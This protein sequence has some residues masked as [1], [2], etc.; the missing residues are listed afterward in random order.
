MILGLNLGS[1][2]TEVGLLTKTGEILKHKLG[3]DEELLQ[4]TVSEQAG[5]RTEIV[6]QWIDAQGADIKQLSAIACRGGRLKPIPSGVYRVN[7][8]LMV[9][10]ASTVHGDH[11]SRLSVIIGEKIAKVAACPLFVVDPISVDELADVARISGLNGVE[12]RSLG[13]MLNCKY[14]ARHLSASLGKPYEELTLIVAHL[15]GGA[16]VSLHQNG[17]LTDLINDFE[18]AF[19]PERMGGMATTTMTALCRDVDAVQLSRFIEGEGGFYSYL[20]TKNLDEVNKMAEAGNA[21]AKLLKD[22]YLYQQ[23]KSIGALIAAAGGTIDALAITGGIAHQA[24]VINELRAVFSRCCPIEVYPG[25]FE[26]EALLEGAQKAVTGLVP[27]LVYPDGV[28]ENVW[29]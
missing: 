15:G 9:D 5:P 14:V 10:S 13:H 20:G 25:S 22:A 24:F 7:D 11:A 6:R 18:G 19:S 2:S 27:V 16:T 28:P 4:K 29:F 8:A 26:M 17:R 3:H 21:T 1:T 23:K 12:R